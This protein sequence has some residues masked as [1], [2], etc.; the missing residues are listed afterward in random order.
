MGVNLLTTISLE[1]K[2]CIPRECGGEPDEIAM[3]TY[4][5]EYSPRVRGW[6][7][8]DN[9]RLSVKLVFPAFA[10]VDR[11]VNGNIEPIFSIPRMCGGGPEDQIASL[12]KNRVF[13]A[14][15]GVDRSKP[16]FFCRC[17]CYSPHVRG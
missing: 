5:Y 7:L 11:R 14:C 12:K 3:I 16:W 4:V 9:Y 10:G 6:T 13:P 8:S 15:A 17:R 2:K 1:E